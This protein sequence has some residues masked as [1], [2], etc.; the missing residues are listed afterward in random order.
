MKGF[1]DRRY[2]N[3]PVHVATC[4]RNLAQRVAPFGPCFPGNPWSTAV[5]AELVDLLP[6][7]FNVSLF[8][9]PFSKKKKTRPG[10]HPKQNKHSGRTR[11][12]SIRCIVFVVVANQFYQLQFGDDDGQKMARS[13]M[14]D[15]E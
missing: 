14:P 3:G 2:I 5:A 6:G 11:S 4:Y 10:I 1:A 7:G 9:V 15:V 8:Q 12:T 13:G